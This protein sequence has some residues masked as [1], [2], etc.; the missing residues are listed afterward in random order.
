MAV[1]DQYGRPLESKQHVEQVLARLDAL[2]GGASEAGAAVTP[3]TALGVT[4]VLACVDAIARGCAVPGLEVCREDAGGRDLLARD[5]PEFRV[6][7]RRPNEWQ[8]SLEFRRT[9]TAHAA[10][11][12]NGYAIPVRVGGRLKELIPVMPDQVH[13]EDV[14]RYQR[15]YRV[16]DQWG[17]VGV[18]DPS[19]IFHLP[20]LMWDAVRG[21][22]TLRAAREA[23][24]LARAIEGAQARHQRNAGRPNGI[25]FTDQTLGSAQGAGALERI[26]EGWKAVTEGGNR[27]KTAVL[28]YGFKWQSL[29]MSSVDAQLLETRRFQVEEICRAFGVYPQIVMHTDKASTFASAEAFFKAHMQ[30]VLSW[31]EIWIQR[32]DEF[33]LDGAGPLYVRF[34]N[35][36]LEAASLRD[37][38]EYAARM[39]GSGGHASILTINEIRGEFGHAPIPGGDVLYPPSALAKTDPQGGA[40]EE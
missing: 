25:L 17:E 18:F 37:R 3:A 9:L 34:D 32:L 36:K 26:K 22:D 35:R 29:E 21:L 6:L 28:D 30:T 20:N 31:Q 40:G 19:A 8:T 38:G 11:T 15:V 16:F 23:V 33:A 1:L 14:G 39:A 2:G 7:N 12:G 13:I 5:A 24:G 4:T 27:G 10:L